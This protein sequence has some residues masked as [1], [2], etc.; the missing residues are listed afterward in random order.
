M[1]KKSGFPCWI[2]I[3]IIVIPL[4]IFLSF[5]VPYIIVYS[6]LSFSLLDSLKNY[7]LSPISGEIIQLS[8]N[9]YFNK[10][11]TINNEINTYSVFPNAAPKD[12][13]YFFYYGE[14]VKKSHSFIDRAELYVS[15]K[16]DKEEFKEE[17]TR[18]ETYS[19]KNEK[20]PLKSNNLF[21]LP[22][23]IFSYSNGYFF[24][25]LVDDS[26]QQ[27]F[28]IICMEIGTLESVVFDKSLAPS[29]S[30]LNSDVSSFGGSSGSYSVWW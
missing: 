25:S 5:G 20:K 18:L 14:N 19:G 12:G 9:D 30:L 28:Y 10:M 6:E 16:W 24:Y 17:K 2:I 23:F 11:S 21:P 15:C 1:N 3:L 8:Q 4:L 22:S 7:D 13:V 27:I 29:K 26:N